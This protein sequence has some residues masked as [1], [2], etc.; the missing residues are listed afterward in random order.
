MN[1][2]VGKV[3]PLGAVDN[4]NY[5]GNGDDAT[6]EGGLAGRHAVACKA[7]DVRLVEP[8]LRKTVQQRKVG[9]DGSAGAP[10]RQVGWFG[11]RSPRSA[12]TTFLGH[13]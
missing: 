2:L 1:L 13:G 7:F 9:L 10:G 3:L 4:V 8:E 6:A 11:S 5:R 12:T